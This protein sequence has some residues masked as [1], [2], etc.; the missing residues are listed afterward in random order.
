MCRHVVSFAPGPASRPRWLPG[1]VSNRTDGEPVSTSTI[2]AT[3]SAVAMTSPVPPTASTGTVS[4]AS[5]IV[6][7][8]K[9]IRPSRKLF[10]STSSSA[11]W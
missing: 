3:E 11:V 5:L 8:P 9:V 7:P 4:S 1:A 10:P 2:A 6:L